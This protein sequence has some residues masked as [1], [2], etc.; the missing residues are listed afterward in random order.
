MPWED[1]PAEMRDL[2]LTGTDERLQVTYRNRY[3]RKRTYATQ[4]RG[5]REE[6]GAPLPRE[7][8]RGDEREDRAV[9]VAAALPGVRRGAAARRVARGARGG[10]A[11]RRVLRPVRAA[12]ARVAAGSRAVGDRP[13]RR[14][15]D[16]A[17]DRRA[18]AVLGERWDRLPVDGPR[19]RDAVG[20]RGAADPAG[21]ADRI[22]AGGRA[23][24]PRR[25]LDRV[26]SAR[27]LEVDRDARTVARPGEH[28]DRGRAR[29]AD[30][31]SGRPSR[32][33]GSGRGG[34]RREGRRA[35]HREAGGTRE[36]LGDGPVPRGD[37]H[38]RG[39]E[40]AADTARLCGDRRRDPA[41]PA[42]RRREGPARRARLA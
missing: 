22:L 4:L 9:H 36:G 15:A 30:D 23:V 34:A 14:A 28:G 6:P 10:D 39:A 18:A 5:D 35:G 24:H 16:P 32:R 41:Q 17:R 25:A 42:R 8:V 2:F 29:R 37:A 33:H 21:D 11:D 1:L 7:R 20:G 19:R 26:A 3:G 27:Q 40:E 38:D 12:R 31:A 13:P